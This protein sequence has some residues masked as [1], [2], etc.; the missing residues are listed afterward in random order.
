VTAIE[1]PRGLVRAGLAAVLPHA[2][3]ESDDTPDLGR[4]RLV[5]TGDA[6]LVWATD[7]RTTGL[8]RIE[9]PEY[10]GDELPAWDMPAAA[11]KK[12]LV[13]FRGPSNADARQMWDD[14]PMRI[15][16]TDTQVTFTEVGSIVDGQ[17]LTVARVV[18]AGEDRYPDVPRE[19]T[20]LAAAVAEDPSQVSRVNVEALA[21]FVAAAKAYNPEVPV[22]TV[23]AGHGVFQVLVRVG[24]A[25]TGS[26]PAYPHAG[27]PNEVRSFLFDQQRWWSDLLEPLRREI[28]VTVTAQTSEDLTRQAAQV[29]RDAGAT[30]SL[31]VVPALPEDAS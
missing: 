3:H 23:H 20:A 31:R 24:H 5:A 18:P 13:V 15:E 6:L 4:V 17:S 7:H 21:R 11:V 25:F 10:T 1:A 29:L 27:A 16:P 28:P 26:A 2:G 30:V 14:Q 8:A 22:L 19:L 9:H 12:V